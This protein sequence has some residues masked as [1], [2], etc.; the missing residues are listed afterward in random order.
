[1][2]IESKHA[3]RFGYLKSDKWKQVRLDALLREKGKCQ[4]CQEES[5]YN[6]AHHIWYPENIYD[7][8]EFHLVILCRPCHDF[9]HVAFPECKTRDEEAGREIWMK[10]YR[11]V[12]TWRSSKHLLFSSGVLD[13]PVTPFTPKDLRAAHKQTLK[14]LNQALAIIKRNGIEVDLTSDSVTA[15][16]PTE[17]HE[18][19]VSEVCAAIKKWASNA[20]CVKEEVADSDFSI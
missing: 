19:T 7:T 4:I 5:I 14:K 9:V 20:N 11:A 12:V 6:D 16:D 2:S 10:F 3:Y 18:L 13:F 17:K 15:L 8:Q 1:M